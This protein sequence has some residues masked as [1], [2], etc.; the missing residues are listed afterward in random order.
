MQ[1]MEPEAGT[2]GQKSHPPPLS[3]PFP[4]FF[5]LCRPGQSSRPGCCQPGSRF[6]LV[7][8]LHFCKSVTRDLLFCSDATNQNL[9]F[10]SSRRAKTRR[11]FF[12]LSA[13]RVLRRYRWMQL[14]FVSFF[15]FFLVHFHFPSPSSS[16]F[17]HHCKE[18]TLCPCLWSVFPLPHSFSTHT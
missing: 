8:C 14:V 17:L 3:F 9:P 11:V 2:A 7:L 10:S 16:S 18:W 5:F 4:P 12:P 1:S 6:A 13:H 15:F